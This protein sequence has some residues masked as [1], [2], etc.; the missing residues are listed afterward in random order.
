MKRSFLLPFAL[1]SSLSLAACGGRSSLTPPADCGPWS[2]HDGAAGTVHHVST[3]FAALGDGSVVVPMSDAV[4]DADGGADEASYRYRV[5]KLDP[6]GAIAWEA[7]GGPEVVWFTAAARGAADGIY[8]AGVVR[9]GAPSVLGAAVSCPGKGTCSFVAKLAATGEAAWVKAFPSSAASD[10]AYPRNL[11]VTDDG[12]ITLEGSFDGTLDLG[13]G[14]ASGTPGSYYGNRFLARLSPSGECLWSRAV[15]GPPL[16]AQTDDHMAVGDAGD[17]AVTLDLLAHAGSSI[18]LGGGPVPFVSEHGPAFAVAKYAPDGDLVFAKVV[19]GGS[20][21]AWPRVAVTHAGEVLFSGSYEGEI[22]LG[23]GPRGSAGVTRQFVTKLGPT[24]EEL[25]TSDI[26]A[27]PRGEGDNT[28]PFA[29]ALD[30]DGSF[31]LAGQGRHGMAILGEPVPSSALFTASYDGEGKPI[32]VQ[33]F[34][35]SGGAYGLAL[36]ARAPGALVLAGALEGTLDLGQGP[37]GSEGGSVTFDAFV[38]RIC[39]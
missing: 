31:Y 23:G 16:W 18:D 34:P 26:A 38:A 15:K 13:C 11:A 22:D 21:S 17:V 28:S 4:T 5:R 27:G 19:S 9:P 3:V 14:P 37:F 7:E 25:W 8:L 36:S 30:G 39:R 6:D 20:A 32:D 1:S 35:L 33:T 10:R 12:R 29:L 24:G 2:V